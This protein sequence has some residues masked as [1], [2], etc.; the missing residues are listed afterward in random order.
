MLRSG[1]AARPVKPAAK[2]TL[3]SPPCQSTPYRPMQ[4]MSL[5]LG[6]TSGLFLRPAGGKSSLI[7]LEGSLVTHLAAAGERIAAAVPIGGPVHK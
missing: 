4:T 5:F 1:E 2:P 6:T 7:G 3:T